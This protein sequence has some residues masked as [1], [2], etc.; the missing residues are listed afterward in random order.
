MKSELKTI[1]IVFASFVAALWIA[2][3]LREFL[4]NYNLPESDA[5][6]IAGILPRLLIVI[7]A[8]RMINKLSLKAYNDFMKGQKI[9]NLNAI[10]IPSTFIILGVISNW[11]TYTEAGIYLLLL[12]T[13]SVIIVG[14]AEEL[15]FRGLIQ[16]LFIRHF[17]NGKKSLYLGSP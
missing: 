7:S 12:F 16:P 17:N 10:V 6:L 13:F 14:M 1:V 8:I 15:V 11:N 3:T 9:K 4:A 2:K 5:R